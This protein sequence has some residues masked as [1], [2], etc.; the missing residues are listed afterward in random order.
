MKLSTIKPYERNAKKHDRKQIAKIAESITTFGFNQPIVVDKKNVIIVGHG[1]W[2]AAKLLGLKEVPTIK[3]DITEDKARAYRLTDNKLN[4]SPWDMELV[5]TELK[6]LGEEF[7]EVSGFDGGL[8]MEVKEDMPEIIAGAPVNAR[9]GDMYQLGDHRLICGD[10]EAPAT[11]ERLLGGHKARLIFT[12]PPYS[13][14]YNS[15]GIS[16][17]SA[18]FGGTGGKIFNDDKTPAQALEW[19]KKILHQLYDFS[20]KDAT[21]YWWYATRLTEVNYQ[22]FR[23]SKWH[24]SQTVFWLKNSI[25]FSPGQMYH[26]IKEPCL[27]GWKEKNS[28]YQNRVF[29]AYSEL[30]TIDKKKFS[31]YLD[32]WYEHRDPTTKYIHPTQK[33]VALAERALKRSSEKGDIVLDAFAGS[34]STLMACQQLG[35]KCYAIELDPK[36][37]D[38]I[39][40][41]WEDFT[42]KKVKKL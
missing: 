5:I 30:W 31:D 10:S 42:K 16:Y 38:A 40:K 4:E 15:G 29:S 36:Y 22:A 26:R 41:R 18:K 32:V 28:P 37:V 6:E 3:L 8:I 12:D 7:I 19:Y 33:P 35:R 9:L 2:E 24:S 1:R 34:G 27:V 17:D 39:I 13:I 11:Y 25:I 21:I 20:T 14:D 23:E